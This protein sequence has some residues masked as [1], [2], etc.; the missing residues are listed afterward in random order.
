MFLVQPHSC[1]GTATSART[2]PAPAP[3]SPDSPARRT[4]VLNDLLMLEA[5]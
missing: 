3:F 4:S 1:S 2:A 5:H